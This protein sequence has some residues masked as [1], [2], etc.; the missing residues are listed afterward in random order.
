MH[1][2]HLQVRAEGTGAHSWATRYWGL[3]FHRWY[4][5]DQ[6]WTQ[7]ERVSMATGIPCCVATTREHSHVL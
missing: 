5:S 6:W 1:Y 7:Q 3:V 4:I 2:L